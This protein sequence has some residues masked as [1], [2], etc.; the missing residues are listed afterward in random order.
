MNKWKKKYTGNYVVS[1]KVDGISGL[2]VTKKG[3]SKL[4]TRGNGEV[5]RNI[6]FI[7]PYIN[8]P[9]IANTAFRG[10]IIMLEEVFNQKYKDEYKNPRS[11]VAGITNADFNIQYIPKY[12][13]LH[14]IC[15]EVIKP[16][17]KPSD[18][19]AFLAKYGFQTIQ[20]VILDDVNVENLS[21]LLI[22]W[23]ANYPYQNDGII[24]ADN[25]LYIRWKKNPKHAFA[26]KMAL[27]DQKGEAKVLKVV[28]T[29]SK[30]GI[31]KPVVHIEPTEIGGVTIVKAT[32]FNADF[33]EKNKIGMGAVVEVIRSGDVI[34][35]IL[36]IITP[37][38]TPDMPKIPYEWNETHKDIV[39]TNITDNIGVQEKI[40]TRFFAHIDVEGLR[41]GNVKRLMKAGYNSI[42][43]IINMQLA[44]FLKVPGFKQKLANKIY[45]SIHQKLAQ[46][47]LVELMAAS[48]MFGR[49]MGR[50]RLTA[51]LNA[52]PDIIKGELSK[53][54]AETRIAALHGFGE[55]TAKDFVDHLTAF[56]QF[57]K[58]AHLEKKLKIKVKKINTSH[59]L[60]GKSIVMDWFPR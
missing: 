52:Y 37:A 12:K 11:A 15:Y 41:A 23:R 31:L 19:M 50:R 27:A 56:L 46:V 39:L 51:I 45:T 9:L 57:V 33:I 58:D 29:P 5:G 59:P 49:G 34:P 2:L 43:K 25:K 38:H 55:K 42:E 10:E 32:G 3:K 35:H 44:D 28:W 13:D 18:Q 8:V 22:D 16:R 7:L 36:R 4:Y 54:E 17:L 14:F 1:V 48:N 20:Y 26:F 40:I 21:A 24:V 47:S 60:F 53:T 6:S 30:D